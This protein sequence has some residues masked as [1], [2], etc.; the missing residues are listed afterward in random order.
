MEQRIYNATKNKWDKL[1][2]K[3]STFDHGY[4]RYKEANFIPYKIVEVGFEDLSER[5]QNYFADECGI[6]LDYL[7]E[8]RDNLPDFARIERVDNNKA[9]EVDFIVMEYWAQEADGDE[10]L[11]GLRNAGIAI[12]PD[13]EAEKKRAYV[14]ERRDAM[15]DETVFDDD[16][17]KKAIQ[18]ALKGKGWAKRDLILLITDW[19]RTEGFINVVGD[20]D[21]KEPD[22]YY[23]PFA[24]I[25]S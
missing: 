24:Y 18:K 13:N 8:E 10:L 19:S 1:V 14:F 23:E 22:V 2:D 25:P 3:L 5:E 7:E 11:D 9:S 6:N 16:D 20:P 15:G 21:N 17:V 12:D 4:Y